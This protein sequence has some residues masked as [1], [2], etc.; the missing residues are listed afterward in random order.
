M[1]TFRDQYIADALSRNSTGSNKAGS[2][3]HA[4]DYLGGIL[5][6]KSKRFASVSDVFTLL[7]VATIRQLYE[8]ICEQQLLGE[9]GIFDNKFK[10][11]YWKYRFYS[12]ALKDYIRFLLQAQY[13]EKLWKIYDIPNAKPETMTK[14]FEA[15]KLN[16]ADFLEEGD[17]VAMS[18]K[19]ILRTVKTRIN[20]R[21]FRTIVLRDYATRCC[22]T[23]LTLPEVLR[24]SHIIPWAED[25]QNRMNPANGLCLSATYDAA[26]DRYLVSFDE[27][28]RL[29][30]APTLK[31][32]S[33]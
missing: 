13:E 25:A 30:L 20:Q 33:K 10:P 9:K 29:V 3:V 4:L 18:G 26:F 11:S 14:Q 19:D 24:A 22:V 6:K 5:E 15:V 32:C 31:H 12:S 27:D 16:S 17:L 28:Y 23:G 2:Y 7:D 8:Y 21:F 1:K